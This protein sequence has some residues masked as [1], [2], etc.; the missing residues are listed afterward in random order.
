[1]KKLFLAMTAA[2]ALAGGSA[3]AADL[4]RPVYKAAPPPIEVFDWSGI[5]IGGHVGYGWGRTDVTDHT[6]LG[7][8]LL[9]PTQHFDTNGGLGGVQG[10]W[11]YQFG[12]FVLGT[13]VDFSWANVKGDQTSPFLLGIGTINRS[14]KATWIGT[15]TTRLGY[16]WDRVLFYTKIGA[17]WAHFDYTDTASIIIVG[18]VY[19][20][21]ASENRSGWTV[22]TGIEWAFLGGWSAKIEYDYIDFG[23]RTIDFNPVAGVIPVNLD[24]DQRVSEIKFGLNYRFGGMGPLAARY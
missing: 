8:I 19:T 12:R 10:G 5:Y 15:A 24:I 16:A 7:N 4:A 3:S 9:I 14:S 13:E 2:V 23:R 11:N 21:P 20:S 17:A 6:L 22:G 1:M 18:P